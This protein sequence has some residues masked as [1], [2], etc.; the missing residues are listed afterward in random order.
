MEVIDSRATLAQVPRLMLSLL[1][2]SANYLLLDQ[3]EPCGYPQWEYRDARTYAT[4]RVCIIG[5]ALR[6]RYDTLA[7]LRC[8]S[9][10]RGCDVLRHPSYRHQDAGATGWRIPSIR[11]CSAAKNLADRP[12]ERDHGPDHDWAR[13]W[14]RGGSGQD[15]RR[16][17]RSVGIDP[18]I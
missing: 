3:R 14:Y 17:G 15:E 16:T 2:G 12:I 8:R 9:G 18:W 6:A 5:D 11:H 7:R 10:H 1:M 13:G 4:G